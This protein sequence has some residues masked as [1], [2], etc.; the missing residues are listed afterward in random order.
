MISPWKLLPNRLARRISRGKW[1][2]W[3][4]LSVV[5]K[6]V[7]VTV[8]TAGR[9]II[10]MPPRHGKSELISHWTPVWFLDRWPD[11][12][13]ILTTYDSD[14]AAHWGRKARNTIEENPEELDVRVS[15]DSSAAQRWETT[16][17]GGMITAGVGGPIMGRG[18]KLLI[19]DDPIKNWQEAQSKTIREGQINWF[20]STF[21]TRKE[22]GAAIIVLMTRWHQKDLAGYLETE[23]KDKW[24]I[25]RFPALA[26]L[27]DPLGRPEGKA[28]CPDRYDEPAL[29]DIKTALGSCFWA[30]LYQQRPAPLEGGI[31][32]RNWWEYYRQ[33]PK[34]D[35]LIQSWDTAFKKGKKTSR[36]C[37]ETWGRAKAGYFLVDVW[38][39][40]V[41]Y[42]ELKR[43]AKAL[44]DKWKPS[45]VLIEDMASGQSLT[46]EMKR[47]TKIPVK[48]I[49]VAEG[50][51]ITRANFVSPLIEA[52]RGFLPKEATWLA[53][54]LDETSN[55][56]N[57]EYS[58]QVDAMSQ[59]LNYLRIEKRFGIAWV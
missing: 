42:P 46:Q 21:Y 9:L 27:N 29:G 15:R 5:A 54:F 35:K 53:D 24:E 20:N 48:A 43:M 38:K 40:K 57:S 39:D 30:G 22:P 10:E 56:P 23:H 49:P 19:V 28:L 45:I 25:I 32:K 26:E 41:E 58:D 16:N 8:M 12:Q 31:F 18:G 51:K 44:Y 4:Y 47:D 1:I 55:F 14:F 17:G 34:F 36:S 50:D 7:A 37:C 2:D 52:G 11:E 33:Q 59:A 6:K 13:V 3:E